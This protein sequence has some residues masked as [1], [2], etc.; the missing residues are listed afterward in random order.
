M[1]EYH[2]ELT[3][4]VK[5]FW[6]TRDKQSK[7][8]GST[9]GRKDQG[10]RA[11]VTGG[12]Q[13]DGFVDLVRKISLDAGID[14]SCIYTRSHLELPGYY[15]PE[16][17]WDLIIVAEEVLLAVIEFKSQIGPSFGNNYNNRT[18]EAIGNAQDIWTAFREGAFSVSHR[19]WL[20]Y[21]MLLEDVSGSTTP[22]TVR[23]PHF[24]VFP[25]FVGSSYADRYQIL[26]DKLVRERLYDAS[27]FLMA[28]KS[29]GKQGKYSE[30][31][32]DLR[33]AVFANSLEAKLKS[34]CDSAD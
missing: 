14:E 32:T 5:L 9:S 28:S 31:S 22:V 1:N 6:R 15:R 30:P 21:V 10:A 18:E 25:E 19:P 24:P 33:F 12:K 4:A 34:Y 17:K 11:A 20:G 13:M 7:R 29:G 26:M 27:C 3:K 8:Q 2:E 16:K 23:E